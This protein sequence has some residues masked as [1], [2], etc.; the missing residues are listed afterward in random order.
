MLRTAQM[1][2]SMSG[3]RRLL[4]GCWRWPTPLLLGYTGAL[5]GRQ[6]AGF[7]RRRWPGRDTAPGHVQRTLQQEREAFDDLSAVA[8]LTARRLGG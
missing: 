1:P 5:L 3:P 7:S 2:E 4:L 8:M 6:T